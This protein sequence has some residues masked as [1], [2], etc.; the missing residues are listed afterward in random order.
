MQG[1]SRLL[2]EERLDLNLDEIEGRKASGKL[3]IW[4]DGACSPNPGIG[5]WGWIDSNG[6]SGCGGELETTNN[7]MELIAI[8]EAI[9]GLPNGQSAIVYSDSQYCVNGLTIWHKAWKKKDWMD[10]DAP[11]INRD[12]WIQI[13]TH[14]SRL[15]ISLVW[16][17][18]H[19]GNLGNEKADELALMGRNKVVK[20]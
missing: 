14:T 2:Q 17:R 18:G 5:G 20:K 4:T 10:R 13:D 16:V 9:R 7:R 8:Y 3:L 11:R 15:H 6:N 1:N 19:N 12:L